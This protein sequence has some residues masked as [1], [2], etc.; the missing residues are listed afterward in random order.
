MGFNNLSKLISI[1]TLENSK[2]TDS[3]V[4]VENLK[5]YSDGLICLAGGEFGIIT[6]NFCSN[7][8]VDSVIDLLLSIFCENFFRTAKT[9][10]KYQNLENYILC[11]SSE[12][13]FQ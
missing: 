9:R 13:K 4:T 8:L 2:N 6:K 12:K 3:F 10:K 11:K 7:N 5:Q 1:S